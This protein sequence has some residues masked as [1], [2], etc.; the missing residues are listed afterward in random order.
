ML[1]TLVF[2]L[3][4]A[5][6]AGHCSAAMQTLVAEVLSAWRSAERL[7]ATLP[8]GTPEHAMAERACA[9]LRQLFH[10]LTSSNDATA[11]NLDEAQ[12]RAVMADLPSLRER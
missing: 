9:Q 4:N 8:P 11:P 7:A 6:P 1:D 3:S 2:V 5:S 12:A 10:E